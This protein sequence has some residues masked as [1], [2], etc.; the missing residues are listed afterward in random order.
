MRIMYTVMTNA[1]YALNNGEYDF[2][3]TQIHNLS[4]NDFNGKKSIN[5]E[6]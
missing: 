2:L 5:A 6:K 1:H 4:R 3:P